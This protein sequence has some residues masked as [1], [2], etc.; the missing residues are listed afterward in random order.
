M[1]IY[2]YVRSFSL[3]YLCFSLVSERERS[4]A[5]FRVIELVMSPVYLVFLFFAYVNYHHFHCISNRSVTITYQLFLLNGHTQILVICTSG[6][7]NV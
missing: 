6:M 1:P 2:L 7:S 4:I 5:P 3:P